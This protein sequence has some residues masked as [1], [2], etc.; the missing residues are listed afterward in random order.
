MK[1]NVVTGGGSGIGFSVS[2]SFEKDQLVII[3]GRTEEKLKKAVEQLAEFGVK[4]DYKTCDISSR[5]SVDELLE[6]AKTKG[7]LNSVVNCAGVSGDVKNL[8][9]VFNID[10]MGSKIIVDEVYKYAEKGTVLVLIASMMGHVVPDNDS[11][12]DYLANPDR[13][14][15][16]EMFHSLINGDGSAAY[17]FSKKG[18]LLMVQKNAERYGEK[19]AR[20]VSVSP[21]IIMTAMAK[22]AQ[23]NH[24][25]QMKLLEDVT[26]MHRTGLAEDV[27]DVISFLV[28]EKASF[29]TG[30]DILVDGGL[31][32]NLDKL[33]G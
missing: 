22:K 19:G 21:G 11:Y 29:I 12:N 8:D 17:N 1:V 6:F 28:S 9:L 31:S 14:G 25:E 32:L 23:E 18:A 15:A 3:S 13:E 16:K 26:P 30:S 5:D 24:P 20:I 2:K 33:K 7:D 4:A 27:A 10:L